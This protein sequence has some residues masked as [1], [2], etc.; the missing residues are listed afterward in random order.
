[1]AS[2]EFGLDLYGVPRANQ[3]SF[4]K[5]VGGGRELACLMTQPVFMHG[6]HPFFFDEGP[7]SDGVDALVV[8]AFEVL[9]AEGFLCKKFVSVDLQ[10]GLAVKL[11]VFALI[12]L[13]L[14]WVR[15]GGFQFQRLSIESNVDV[16]VELLDVEL[17]AL[18]SVN[19]SQFLRPLQHLLEQPLPLKP[20]PF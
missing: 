8:D 5:L 17:L 7:L 1:M 10:V 18:V 2:F 13:F 12:P 19:F 16:G 4:C 20:H 6:P 11:N 3:V 9:L 15:F 14:E